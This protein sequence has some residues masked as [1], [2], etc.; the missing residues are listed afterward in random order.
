MARVGYLVSCVAP[1]LELH[2][3]SSG[4]N[5]AFEW[6][7]PP[8]SCTDGEARVPGPGVL[9]KRTPALFSTTSSVHTNEF[10]GPPPSCLVQG[11]GGGN[12]QR[13]RLLREA[14]EVELGSEEMH[15]QSRVLLEAE[16]E[17]EA[18]EAS[19]HDS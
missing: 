2:I 15:V 12:V 8:A 4:H 10:R 16:T 13:L 14:L 11:V 18:L 9:A 6:H 1:V 5:N 19:A 7:A 3:A 17:L